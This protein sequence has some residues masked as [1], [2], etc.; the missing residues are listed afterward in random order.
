MPQG[1]VDATV[2]DRQA[3]IDALWIAKQQQFRWEEEG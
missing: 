1:G 2:A 3:M